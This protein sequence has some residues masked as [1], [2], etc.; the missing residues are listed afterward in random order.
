M[1]SIELNTNSHCVCDHVKILRHQIILV[2]ILIQ[3]I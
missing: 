2:M 1:N 3:E